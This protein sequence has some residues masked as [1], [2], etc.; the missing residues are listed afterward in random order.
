MNIQKNDFKV[1]DEQIKNNEIVLYMKGSK[2]SP[3]CGFSNLVVQILKKLEIDNYL[4][5]NVMLNSNLKENIK[6]YTKWPTIPQLYI[7][8][9]FIGGADI[10]KEMYESGELK[11]ILNKV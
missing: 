9:D 4:D 3:M 8:G 7:R 5:V 11:K 6:K 10:V 1:I 2:E